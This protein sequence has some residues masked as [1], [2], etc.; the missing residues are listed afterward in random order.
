MFCETAWE[1]F[2]I[3]IMMY[4]KYCA[5]DKSALSTDGQM[6]VYICAPQ[7]NV[8]NYDTER[9]CCSSY[10]NYNEK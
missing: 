5:V 6:D 9:Q 7:R 4:H 3:H 2:C 1:T 10:Q 8:S